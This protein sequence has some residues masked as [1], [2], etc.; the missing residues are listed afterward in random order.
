MVV[1]QFFLT[2]FIYSRKSG[3]L[4]IQIQVI[5][6]D[7]FIIP[8]WRSLNIWKGHLTIP[9]RSQRISSIIIFPFWILPH[10]NLLKKFPCQLHG[11]SHVPNPTKPR[12][13][14]FQGSSSKKGHGISIQFFSAK[15]MVWIYYDWMVGQWFFFFGTFLALLQHR[16]PFRSGNSCLRSSSK[17]LFL[18]CW[19]PTN[20][21]PRM[22]HWGVKFVSLFLKVTWK[23]QSLDYF[24]SSINFLFEIWLLNHGR[25]KKNQQIPTHPRWSWR[26]RY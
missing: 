1:G 17:A 7:L 18:D 15:K 4:F 13:F 10:H 26:D 25:W 9:K 3:D 20:I 23:S 21:F 14:S 11:I 8:S 5:Q 2:V 22:L 19:V 16:N 12:H 24:R 6:S